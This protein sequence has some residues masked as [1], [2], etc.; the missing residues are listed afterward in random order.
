LLAQKIEMENGHFQK[1]LFFLKKKFQK[2]LNIVTAIF[3]EEMELI[4]Q[5][6]GD[7]SDFCHVQVYTYETNLRSLYLCGSHFPPPLSLL[8]TL[9][10]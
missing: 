10:E 1:H 3:F 8:A 2:Y 5:V 6:Y 9:P 4:N 7:T